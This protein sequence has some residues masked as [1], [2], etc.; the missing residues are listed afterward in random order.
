MSNPT[1]TKIFYKK[2]YILLNEK[3]MPK[4]EADKFMK[5]YENIMKLRLV[6]S[7]FYLNQPYYWIYGRLINGDKK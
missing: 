1:K 6:E 7:D 5:Q 3:D 4:K 2:Q